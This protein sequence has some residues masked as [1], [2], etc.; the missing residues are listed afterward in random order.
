MKSNIFNHKKML[1]SG[2]N[3]AQCHSKS[4]KVTDTCLDYLTFKNRHINQPFTLLGGLSDVAQLVS[5]CTEFGRQ[6]F[7]L[8]LR[9]ANSSV[10]IAHFHLRLHS[11]TAS[12]KGLHVKPI[13]K[14]CHHKK[15][16]YNTASRVA[17]WP[18]ESFGPSASRF[19]FG[20]AG[21]FRLVW[22]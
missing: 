5:G 18:F 14:V 21:L 20:L 4:F 22:P 1:H 10:Q 7:H 12:Q 6:L 13:A 15:H 17:I 3:G 11:T 16:T 8:V 9:V 19:L 2:H